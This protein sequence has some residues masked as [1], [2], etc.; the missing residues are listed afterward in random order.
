MLSLSASP[1]SILAAAVAAWLFGAVYYVLLG[2]AWVAALGMRKDDLKPTPLPFILSFVAELVMAWV[3]AGI[4]IHV[5]V[6]GPKAGIVAGALCWLGFVATTVLV[7]NA[8]PGRSF[9]LTVID[10]AHWL[11]VLLIMGVVIGLLGPR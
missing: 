4:L 3:L 8:Y 9:M 10:A 6:A 1:L 2:N 5:G 7:N 11:G